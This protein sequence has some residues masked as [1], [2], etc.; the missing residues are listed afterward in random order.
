MAPAT[1]PLTLGTDAQ[2][3]VLRAF[4]EE[5]GYNESAVA[6]R[7]GIASF[8]DFG[9]VKHDA[10]PTSVLERPLDAL[11]RLFLE[12]EP[13]PRAELENLLGAEIL[14]TMDELGL[15]AA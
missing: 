12:C 10:K 15:L 1:M 14:H 8:A 3:A 2:F 7:L 9:S 5:A 13:V 6:G 11:V 4:L